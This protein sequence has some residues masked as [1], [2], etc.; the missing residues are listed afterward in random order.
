MLLGREILE[1][2]FFFFDLIGAEKSDKRDFLLVS[3][4]EL[5]VEFGSRIKINFRINAAFAEVGG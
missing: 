5:F 4:F 2:D 3:V 1:G